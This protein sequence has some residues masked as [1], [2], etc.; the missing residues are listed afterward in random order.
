MD[1]IFFENQ[2]YY[3]KTHFQ[4]ENLQEYNFWLNTSIL[5]EAKLNTIIKPNTSIPLNTFISP[6]IEPNTISTK[7]ESNTITEIVLPNNPDPITLVH[8]QPASDNELCVYSRR[9]RP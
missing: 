3:Q 9:K 4:G 8:T 1:V 2:S 7:T 5:I 6:K